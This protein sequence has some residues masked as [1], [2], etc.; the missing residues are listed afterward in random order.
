MSLAERVRGRGAGH[1]T[2]GP[3]PAGATNRP[4]GGVRRQRPRPG[5]LLV[6]PPLLLVA[7]F[8][9][10]P[11]VSG[12]L[13]TLGHFGGLN[14]VIAAIGLHQHTADHWWGTLGAYREVL[15]S[16]PFLR[17]LTVTV[18][19][20]LL[21]VVAVFALALTV[22]LHA[23][24]TGGRTAK[25]VSA[26]AITPLFLP[27]VIGSYAILTFYAGDGA[28]TTLAHALGWSHAPRLSY[29]IWG[30]VIGQV[31]TNLP[32]AVL[33][34]SSGLA[35]V[36]DALIEAAQDAGAGRTQVVLR[37]LLPMA[38]VPAVITAAFTTI[39]VLGS[40]TVPYLVGPTAPTMLGVQLANTFQ[41]YNQP[42]QSLVMAVVVFALAS[43]VGVAYVRANVR[44]AR[45]AA[46]T[47]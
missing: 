40:Y 27:A 8:V 20:T 16:D 12:V 32:F 14:S 35:A 44:E 30:V 46:A 34:L 6:L 7:F 2:P 25:I 23:R 45:K 19:V 4:T 29:T 10:I 17:S 3:G 26:L 24:L 15:T 33:V 31:W 28:F 1:R 43:L 39:S 36:P 37:V 41:S 18:E 42:Q 13:Y 21:S 11:V 47:R 38:G 22:A 5:G 9:G